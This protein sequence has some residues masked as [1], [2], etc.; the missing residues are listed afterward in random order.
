[1]INV[2]E[3]PVDAVIQTQ[4]C[5]ESFIE[6]LKKGSHGYTPSRAMR[7]CLRIAS[8]IQIG[9]FDMILPNQQRLRF[10]G[11]E[12]GPEGIL[13][14]HNDKM[15]RR[16]LVGGKLGFCESYL[17]GDWSSPDIAQFFE[18][19]LRNAEIMQR[20]LHGKKWFRAL[21]WVLHSFNHNSKDGAKRNIYSHYDIGNDFYE[22]WLDDSMT[23]S[24]ALYKTGKEDL[25]TAQNQKYQSLI[26]HLG[27]KSEH[28]IL[29]IGCG[30][31]GFAEYV[32]TK[33]GAQ[34]TCITISQAQFDYAT[35]R[36][37]KA[38]LEDRVT[39]KLKDYR[40]VNGQF[41]C[42]ISIE[43][44]E[45]VG[46]SYW[47]IYFQTIKKRLKKGGKAGLQ[48]ITIHDDDFDTYR[49]SADYI[50]RYI[51]PG[52]MLPSMEA[53]KEQTEQ[54][55]LKIEGHIAF[56]QDYAKTLHEWNIAFQEAW[57]KLTKQGFDTRFKRLWEQYLC[58]CEAG[59]NTGNIDVIQLILNND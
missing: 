3:I 58:Y 26:D 38:G 55:D 46:E 59:F 56:G 2:S 15:A 20:A 41:D 40:D 44:F 34:V 37:A 6:N 23:Y 14:V 53:L 50:Q 52:G 28:H 30:W 18:M 27:I 1:M 42:I 7:L 22:M 8:N 39:I 51:F 19:I 32:A 21:S 24:S 12:N 36:I 29:E 25:R 35:K 49:R 9:S 54:A 57:P 5:L 16:F 10:E 47:P 17:D 48:I 45:A 31:G 43:M 11:K 33:V 4:K 13:I